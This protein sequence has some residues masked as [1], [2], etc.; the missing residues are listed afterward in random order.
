MLAFSRI[1]R[2]IVVAVS[3]YVL[4]GIFPIS[5]THW[6]AGNACPHLGLVPACYLVMVC[7]AAMGIAALFW[8]KQLSWLFFSGAVPVI[9]M[10]MIGTVL[11]ITGLPTCPRSDTG[12]PL[13]Y[14][15]LL[16]GVM[17]LVVFLYV[18]KLE[19]IKTD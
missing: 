14:M 8:N 4:S 5:F 10:A 11:E 7:Y 15:S 3:L 13:C 16:V 9:F 19:R 17:M 2:L 18:L 1:L 12:L 6:R